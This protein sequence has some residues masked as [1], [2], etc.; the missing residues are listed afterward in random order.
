VPATVIVGLQWGD[1]GKGKTTDFLAEQVAM[2]VRYQ[3]G[4]NAGHTVV[5]GDEV[6]KLHLVPSGVLYPHITS[7]IGSGVVV[8]PATLIGELDMLA[9]RGIDTSRVRVS[10][11]AHVIMPYHVALDRAMEARLGDGKVGTTGR[12][13]GPAYADRAWRVGLRMEDLLDGRLVRAKLAGILPDKNLLLSA[14]NGAQSFGP[15]ELVAQAVEWGERLKPHIADTTWLV[16]DALRRG[17]HVLL[18]GA[19]GTLLDLD[20]GSYPFVTSSNPVAGGA[21]TGGGIGPL[22]VDEVIGVM[23]A[24]STRVGSGPYPTEL[25][26]ATGEGIAARGHEVG[27]TTG[28]PRRVGWFD[29]V[30]LRYAVAVNSVSSIMLNKLDILSGIDPIRLCVAYEVDGRRVDA[31]PSSATVLAGATPIYDEFAGWSEPIHGVRSLA[32]LPENARRYV[33][34]L[35]EHAGVPIVLVSVGPER[36]QTIE[37]AWR[38]MRHRTAPGPSPAATAGAAR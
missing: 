13:I 5:S 7:V 22:Q 28:R 36:T 35:E 11:A 37:R 2:V 34:A 20:H 16:Q 17:D 18:E 27:T 6:F 8:N 24:Y 19:Q 32:D 30:P 26:D 1:E 29:A 38:P 4:D 23:K 21:C 10:T 3:G 25:T 14:N 31:W 15:D 9:A 12:G 33:T